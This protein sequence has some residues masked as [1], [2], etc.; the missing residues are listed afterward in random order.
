MVR[1]CRPLT[2]DTEPGTTFSEVTEALSQAA[3]GITAAIGGK[4]ANL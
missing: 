2:N 3:A 4:V 1:S